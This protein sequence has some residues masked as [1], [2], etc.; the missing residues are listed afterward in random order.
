MEDKSNSKGRAW[1]VTIWP[2]SM[3]NMGFGEM[4]NEENR[5]ND[6]NGKELVEAIREEWICSGKGRTCGAVACI[7]PNDGFHIHA[8]VYCNS[9]VLWSTVVNVFGKANV[10]E[11]RST[12]EELTAYLRKEG[13]H[14]EK[15][16]IV[17]YESGLDCIQ[18]GQGGRSDLRMIEELIEQGKMPEDIMD[19][20]FAWRKYETMIKSACFRKR[21][22]ETPIIRENKVYWHV[23]ESGSGKSYT[24]YELCKDKGESEV[25]VL[26]Y[27]NGGFDKYNGEAV[28]F[29]D[30]FRGQMPYAEL[31]KIT[32]V[33]KVP[34][35]ARYT[36]SVALWREVHIA[37]V[38]PPEKLYE[39]M[40]KENQGIDTQRQLFRRI[41]YIVY[42]WKD[43]NGF[44]KYTIPFEKYIDYATLKQEAMGSETD[45]FLPVPD[46]EPTFGDL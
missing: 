26:D 35:H 2:K 41:K 43:E 16:E 9:K 20:N 1:M 30:E 7:S 12:K 29:M 13:K 33:Y 38:F 34:M 37:T 28:L 14:E 32:D 27:Q 10:R 46:G 44:H 3:C 31:L 19:E 42:H 17:L 4:L 21:Y 36:N 11:Q 40:V 45:G 22:K 8:G 15:G 23:G 5:P 6:G 39:D 24:R 25:F 18:D